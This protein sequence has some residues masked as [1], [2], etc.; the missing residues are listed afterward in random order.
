MYVYLTYIIERMS[1]RLPVNIVALECTMLHRGELRSLAGVR[2]INLSHTGLCLEA[3]E[4]LA[5]GAIVEVSF[6][7]PQ[8]QHQVAIFGT[9]MW[10]HVSGRGGIKFTQPDPEEQRRFE[11][12]FDFVLPNEVW[13]RVR[14]PMKWHRHPSSAPRKADWRIEMQPS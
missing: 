14:L 3:S 10:T 1:I 11:D 13:S 4:M 6:T 9:I 7:L 2:L 12:W 5:Q 8:S